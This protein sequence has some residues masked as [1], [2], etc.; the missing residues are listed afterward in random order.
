M[1][2]RIPPLDLNW[3]VLESH[4]TPMH[5]AG[6]LTFAL[7]EAAPDDY[8]QR[9]ARRLREQRRFEAPWN[10]RVARGLRGKLV[11]HWV[12]V[13][14]V[15]LDHH[16]RHVSLPKPGG[17][18]EL[19]VLVSELHSLPLDLT[20]P[21]WEL[22]L[23]EGLENDRFALYLKIHHSIIDGISVMRLLMDMLSDSDASDV[24]AI[25]TVGATEPDSSGG[26]KRVSVPTVGG[27]F[28]ATTGLAEAFTRPI[29]DHD[30]VAPYTSPRS[31]LSAP[32]NGQRRF[33]THQVPLADVKAAAAASEG[34]V[35]DMVL[36][37]C[38]TVLRRY[39]EEN[40]ALPGR[41]LNAAVPVN[42]RESGDFSVGTNIG[43]LLTS[44]ATDEP[45]PLE[46]LEKIKASSRAAK[47]SMR[48]MPQEARYPYT[49]AA[50]GGIALGQLTRL[51]TLMPPMFSLVISNVPGPAH[52]K[53]LDGARL[54]AVYPISLL[55]RGG[56][57]NVTVTSVDGVMNFGFVGARDTLPHLQ[58]MSS[59]LADAMTELLEVT[60]ARPRRTRTANAA[61]RRPRKPAT[62]SA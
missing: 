33:T 32:L 59:H 29:L 53:Y 50:T 42:L 9:L 47:R 15:D 48:S 7:P 30:L 31:P 12:E 43:H 58:R 2:K 56:A 10:L 17:E 21:L 25:W 28:R 38:G 54:E 4:D 5:V 46:R 20:R 39:L 18:R 40:G 49:I 45:D 13:D 52:A 11:P 34:T 8:M 41:S 23:V 51:D 3:L 16:F 22:H 14:E 27:L 19:A 26:K 37:L 1:S 57:L 62:V 24:T 6:L 44:L 35:N 61:R 36:W 60:G 55:M